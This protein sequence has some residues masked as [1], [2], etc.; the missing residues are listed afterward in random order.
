MEKWIKEW[1][2][3]MEE[4]KEM[5]KRLTTTEKDFKNEGVKKERER[6]RKREFKKRNM[7]KYLIVLKHIQILL[8]TLINL[9]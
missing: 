4:I 2:K 9:Q 1:D 3:K 5:R 6:I 7:E 8:L